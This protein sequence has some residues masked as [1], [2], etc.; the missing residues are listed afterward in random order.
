VGLG[1]SAGGLEAVQELLSHLGPDTGMGFVL[2]QHL[3]PDRESF[4]SDILARS[5]SMPVREATDGT[6]VKPDHLYVIPPNRDIRV[7]Q[8]VL[9]LGRRARGLQRYLPVDHFFRS[10]AEDC[11]PTAIGVVLSGS[12]S[13]GMQGLRAIKNAGG[14]TF[15]QDERSAKY[16]E[17]PRSAVASGAVDLVLPPAGIARELGRLRKHAYVLRPDGTEL[18]STETSVLEGILQ[19]VRAATGADFSY[20]KQNT[21]RRRI[22]RRMA[23]ARVERLE[24][25]AAL[26]RTRREEVDALYD[27]LLIN[28]TSFFREPDAFRTFETKF[29]PALLRRARKEGRLRVWVPGCST[30]EEVYSLAISIF[31]QLGDGSGAPQVQVFGSDLSHAVVERARQGRYPETIASDVSPERLRKY[32]RRTE[33]GFQVQKEVRDVCVFAKHNLLKDPP[34]SRIDVVSCRNVLIYFGSVLQKKAISLFHYALRTDGYLMLGHAEHV[35]TSSEL[36]TLLD[37]KHKIYAKKPVPSRLSFSPGEDAPL[38]VGPLPAAARE[39]DA[40][41]GAIQKEADR[42]VMARYVPPGVV[43]DEDLDVLQFRGHTGT[44]LEPGPGAASLNLTRMLRPGLAHE[45]RAAFQAARKERM[46]ARR[47]GVRMKSSDGTIAEVSLEVVPFA[48]RGSRGRLY[49]VLFEL[50]RTGGEPHARARA[51]P[52]A[53]TARGAGT[54]Q[55]LAATKEYLQTIIEEQ[56]ATNEELMSANEEILSSNEELQS[57]NE[58]LETAREELQS[59]NEELSTVNDELQ[60][61]NV[62][63]HALNNDLSNVLATIQVPMVIVDAEL[64]VRRA[65]PLGERMLNLIPADV[66]RRVTDLRPNVEVPDLPGLVTEVIESMAPRDVEVRDPQGHWFV[67]RVRPYR[68]GTKDVEGVVITWLDMEGARQQSRSTARDLAHAVLASVP[69][70]AALL[71]DDLRVETSN[72]AWSAR[73]GASPDDGPLGWQDPALLTA[74]R[75]VLAGGKPMAQRPVQVP[76]TSRDARPVVLTATRVPAD[77]QE[78]LLVFAVPT[79]AGA[80]GPRP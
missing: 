63:L 21:V 75:D 25:Y 73:F 29:L 23:L 61:R 69:T 56:E 15:A 71:G 49:L 6:T 12:A 68:T 58:E 70:P 35:A 17:M 1:A 7:Q 26:V 42:I 62:E 5:T 57:T 39:G 52:P 64:R 46:P 13:D 40:A 4:L 77:G 36:F 37:R 18:A 45:L 54:E 22:F 48:P 38:D 8:G 30:G 74:L 79:G 2:V 33:G 44:F 47:A 65:T 72:A 27:D 51:R 19:S 53:K 31:D 67:M 9:R 66:G 76:A 41:V 50:A 59:S 34:F 28:V 55:E 10:L 60:D 80:D 14:I 11:G 16:P 3:S 43:V 24:E 32:F 78:S 20:Y